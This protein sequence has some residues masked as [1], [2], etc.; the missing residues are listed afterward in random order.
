MLNPFALTG[1]QFLLFYLLF[2]SAVWLG[3]RWWIARRETAEERAPASLAN[4]PYAIAYLRAGAV[5]ALKIATISLVDRGLLKADEENLKTKNKDALKS[6]HRPIEQAVLSRYMTPGPAEDIL[7]GAESLPACR[8]YR[9][10]LKEQDLLVGPRFMETRFIPG[11]AALACLW[12]AT[13]IKTTIALAQGRHNLLF[14]FILSVVFSVLV[15]FALKKRTT[16]R[17]DALLADLKVLFARLKARANKLASGGQTNEAALVAAV[18]GIAVLPS[19]L[20]PFVDKLY[21]VKSSD[22]GSSGS[23]SSDSGSS[24]GSSC[25]GG[26]GGGCGG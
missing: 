3:L 26:C 21:P 5:E 8:Q 2:G 15:I 4:D 22:S 12:T 23:G 24:C 17:G 6:A 25:G 1:F 19:L 16:A 14:L 10:K 20:F 9:E 13:A 11:V 7:S 18:F